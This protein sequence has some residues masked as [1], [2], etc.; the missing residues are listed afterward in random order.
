MITVRM[1]ATTMLKIEFHGRTELEPCNGRNAL[2]ARKLGAHGLTYVSPLPPEQQHPTDLPEWLIVDGS[3]E[4]VAAFGR[5]A[6]GVIAPG[7]GWAST[8]ARRIL[9]CI[10]DRMACD[11]P[12]RPATAA[13]VRQPAERA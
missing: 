2:H 9:A 3:T 13:D 11:G 5:G 12:A 6:Y 7:T 1:A 8:A 4:A 10:R